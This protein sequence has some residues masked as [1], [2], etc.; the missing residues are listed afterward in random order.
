MS[1]FVGESEYYR[2]MRLASE[3]RFD[4][5]QRKRAFEKKYRPLIENGLSESE[6]INTS[7][8]GEGLDDFRELKAEMEEERAMDEAF[9]RGFQSV[10][11]P[12]QR[13]EH[14]QE[15]TN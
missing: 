8:I 9:L 6:F 2:N 3:R 11:G 7:K 14:T 12:Y 15:Q 10:K 5:E 13:Y 4:E 1:G